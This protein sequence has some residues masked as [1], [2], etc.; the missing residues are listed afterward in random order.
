MQGLTNRQQEVLEGIHQIIS[1]K[2]YPPTV[3]DI[4]QRLGLRSSCTVQRHL[5][6]LER[7]GYIKRDRTKARSVEII[8]APDPT[9]IP[10]PMVPVPVIGAVAAGQPI[11]ALE[12]IE[13]VFPLP[14]DIVKDDQCFMLKVEGDSM[15][16][17]GIFDGDYVVVR[18]QPDAE[19]YS[20]VSL[21]MVR[22]DVL[23]GHLAR[24]RDWGLMP[25]R[26][27]ASVL[28]LKRLVGALNDERPA[29]FV[30]GADGLEYVRFSE[31]HVAFSRGTDAA[32]DPIEMLSRSIALD[33]RRNGSR[34]RCTSLVLAGDRPLDAS[35]LVRRTALRAPVR[36]M[37]E[38]PV[39]GLNGA[40]SMDPADALCIAAALGSR[41][42][43]PDSNL[44][45]ERESRALALRRLP[46]LASALV[47]A[48]AWLALVLFSIG[49]HYVS[50]EVGRTER[51]E[52]VIRALEGEVGD[53][54]EK[55]E[56]LE[57][58]A[59]ERG[60]VSLPLRV[61][62]ELYEQTPQAIALNSLSYD[63]WRPL[64]FGGE[65]PSFPV[66]YGY[67]NKLVES[68]LFDNVEI[69]HGVKPRV[70]GQELVEFKVTCTVREGP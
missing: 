48:V 25:S 32:D 45:P 49:Y 20:T 43:G 57:L 21:F 28:S 34:E 36:S 66:L 67:V 40:A 64:V 2:G 38:I 58:L 37:R 31:G 26:I 14:R 5:E 53:L 15:I 42:P 1:E 39:P 9:M 7:K 33:I 13:E 23:R 62:L 50:L 51:A 12:N 22:R 19:D 60:R 56:A 16:E 18:Q 68:E 3:R 8:Q 41:T 61:V 4:G 63:A 55:N 27:E 44:L 69:K 47:A 30:V 65:A 54:N 46:R 11:L 70:G 29:V 35:Q 24:L 17:A 52:R 10:V 6:A 59:G